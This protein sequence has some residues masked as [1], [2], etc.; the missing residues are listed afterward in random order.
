MNMRRRCEN[1][2]HRYKEVEV[3]RQKLDNF[4]FSANSYQEDVV[5]G[6]DSE[7]PY[8]KQHFKIA[9][10]GSIEYPRRKGELLDKIA[11]IRS[12]IEE[13]ERYI[14]SVED[15]EMRN[16]LTMRYELGMTLDQIAEQYHYDKSTVSKKI[17]KFWNEKQLSTNSTF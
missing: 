1:L 13:V 4:K 6:S 10:Y 7:F 16:I 14:S 5:T 15:L 8:T 17:K 9:G 11:K 2:R 3:E 12:E